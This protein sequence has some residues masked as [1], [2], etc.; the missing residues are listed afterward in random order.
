M[1]RYILLKLSSNSHLLFKYAN[2]GRLIIFVISLFV[3]SPHCKFDYFNSLASSLPYISSSLPFWSRYILLTI[4]VVNC[5][6][7]LYVFLIFLSK[8]LIP[9][10][11]KFSG[12]LKVVTPKFSTAIT[13]IK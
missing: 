7:I 5:G 4:A 8:G 3:E 2:T 13:E 11:S 9:R 1:S 12:S 6:L 10:A